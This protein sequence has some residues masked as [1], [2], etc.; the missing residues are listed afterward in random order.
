MPS[1][2]ACANSAPA[3]RCDT[4]ADKVVALRDYLKNTYP[5]DYF[6]PPQPPGT[7]A[8]DQFLFVDRRGVC[9]HFVS[10]LVVMLRSVGVPARLVAGYGSGDY[11]AITGYY[12]VHAD[13]AHAW[14]EVY[15]PGY[16][17]VPFDPT[18]GWRGDLQTGPVRRWVFSDLMG[19]PDFSRVSGLLSGE[20]GAA[21]IAFLGAAS[22]ILRI[23]GRVLGI[24]GIA[25]AFSWGCWRL[26]RRWRERLATRPHGLRDHPNRRRILAAYRRAQRRLRT[27]PAPTQT[28]QEHAAAHKELLG[29][30]AAV[31]VAA[32]RPEPP[33]DEWVK[34][35][36]NWQR[37]YSL[38]SGLTLSGVEEHLPTDARKWGRDVH[39]HQHL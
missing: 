8:V 39:N 31:D 12:E 2:W 23:A 14:A 13:D 15:F 1:S 37:W 18:P 29:L 7:D 9:E 6:P 30:A 22:R 24:S 34:R 33:D 3:I 26:L 4:S 10:A 16:G 25:V 5:Y 27:R 19:G 35:A 21:G 20:I 38:R 17:W 28:V 32:Y 11:N 36:E